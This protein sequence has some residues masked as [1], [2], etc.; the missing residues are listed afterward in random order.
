MITGKQ[1]PADGAGRHMR[2]LASEAISV[3]HFGFTAA[4]PIEGHE[5]VR[6]GQLL[7]GKHDVIQDL[8]SVIPVIALG[9]CPW[10]SM[11]E[12]CSAPGMKTALAHD[13]AGGKLT[14]VC[15]ERNGLRAIELKNKLDSMRVSA[16]VIR[17]DA[18]RGRNNGKDP[19]QTLPL[20]PGL[21]FDRVFS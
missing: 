18:R 6:L 17:A 10:M 13:I 9:V 16:H 2:L 15:I 3:Q 11:L 21:L 8:A 7:I 5:V 14:T 1:H 12:L 20:R 19:H 4:L